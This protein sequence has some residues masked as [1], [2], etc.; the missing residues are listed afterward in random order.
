MQRRVLLG[1]SAGFAALVLAGYR[2]SPVASG[3]ARDRP[4]GARLADLNPDR[5]WPVY[6]RYHLLIVVQRDDEAG[7]GCAAAVADVLVRFL[8]S[9]RAQT[10]RAVDAR[11]VGVLLATDQQDI[12]I[13]AEA[14]ADA[15]V[16]GKPPFADIGGAPLR[17][18]VSF[19]GHLLVCRPNFLKR[20]AYLIAKTL[21][22]HEDALPGPARLPSGI[23]AAHPG[24]RAYFAGEE[25]PD[26]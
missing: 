2:P 23:V 15:L 6:R 21:S 14:D 25:M 4:V 1:L 7:G 16:L 8:P 3:K 10:V 26:D 13:M 24:A 19:A 17:A 20:H 5:M 18:I 9:S 11:R 22:E 12:A